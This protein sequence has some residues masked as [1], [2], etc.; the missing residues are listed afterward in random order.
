MQV[1]NNKKAQIVQT[2]FTA[3]YDTLDI[4]LHKLR[5][6]VDL[7]RHCYTPEHLNEN[8]LGFTGEVLHWL[9]IEAQELLE[10]TYHAERKRDA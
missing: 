8:T 10:E 2:P 3:S 9:I 7:L 1:L 6:L 5:A 4:I